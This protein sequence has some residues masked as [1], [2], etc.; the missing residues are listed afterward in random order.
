MDDP[1]GSDTESSPA[2]A[3][4]P[5]PAAPKPTKTSLPDTSLGSHAGPG[6]Q[7]RVPTLR[8]ACLGVIG[9][10]L[11]ELISA[12]DEII[13]WL[14]SDDRLSL[15]AVARRQGWVNEGSWRLFVDEAWSVLDLAKTGLMWKELE[16]MLKMVPGIRAIDLSGRGGQEMCTW[17]CTIWEL[18]AR[19][20]WL[21]AH[22]CNV[23]VLKSLV[24]RCKK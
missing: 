6:A 22:C 7:P 18:L 9:R 10:H 2:S 8:S 11:E 4:A 17:M 15:F 5:A 20:G 3:P 19:E 23:D 24:T 21:L 16:E 14:P 1:W 12:G 13:P